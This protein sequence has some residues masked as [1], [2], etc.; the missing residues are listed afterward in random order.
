MWQDET[1][2]A[3]GELLV[4]IATAVRRYKSEHNLSL[5]AEVA[6]LQV[7]TADPALAETLQAATADLTSITRA[8]AVNVGQLAAAGLT[9]V[10][11]TEALKVELL[12]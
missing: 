8:Q 1:A 10:L 2:I 4:E 6:Q 3:T 12:Q 5:G 9:S 7:A 11:E